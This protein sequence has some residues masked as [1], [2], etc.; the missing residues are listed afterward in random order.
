M[1]FQ[2]DEL[3]TG[4]QQRAFGFVDF[5]RAG[6]CFQGGLA[7]DFFLLQFHVLA[8]DF[9]R[10]LRVGDLLIVLADRSVFAIPLILQ[11]LDFQLVVLRIDSH[12][13]FTLRDDRTGFAAGRFFD[14]R[15][16]DFRCHTGLAKGNDR[17][18]DHEFESLAGFGERADTFDSGR[19]Q[20]L[21]HGGR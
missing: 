11:L 7:I 16:G 6:E 13:D 21:K 18:V 14:H 2:G 12:Q 9:D 4:L 5:R 15:S 10:T 17:P 20:R 8:S 3:L 1:V 19:R